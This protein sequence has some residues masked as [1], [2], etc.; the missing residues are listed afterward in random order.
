MPSPASIQAAAPVLER[1]L[2]WERELARGPALEPGRA[3]V[4]ALVPVKE[5]GRA[6]VLALV[7]V[8]E[9]V[10]AAWGWLPGVSMPLSTER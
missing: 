2:G 10:P 3:Q 7:Q 1:V 5:P 8:K 6:Q 4:L 9:P